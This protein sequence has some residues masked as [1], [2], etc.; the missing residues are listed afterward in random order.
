MR[1]PRRGPFGI[2]QHRRDICSM[3]SEMYIVYILKSLSKDNWHYVGSTY[4]LQRRLLQ[5][6][7]GCTPS[8]KKYRPLI[9]IYTEEYENLSDAR[10]REWFLKHPRG[11]LEKLEILRKCAYSSEDRASASEAEGR[12]F[13]SC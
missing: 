4:N 12:R 2:A 9:L 11:Y 3:A 13:K 1:P 6:H 5:H 10:K 7:K 8:T